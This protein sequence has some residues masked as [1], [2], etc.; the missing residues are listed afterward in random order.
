MAL[1]LGA[2]LPRLVLVLLAFALGTATLTFAA[3]KQMASQ[4]APPAATTPAQPVT[5]VVPDVEK[6]AYVFAKGILQD[7]GFAWRLGPGARGFAPYTVISQ[8][9]APGTKVVDTGA[10]LVTLRL[11]AT[12]GYK[13]SRHTPDSASP[14]AGTAIR[15]AGLAT[16][17]APTAPKVKPKVAPKPAAKPMPKARVTKTKPRTSKR[18]AAIATRKPDFV[19][20]GARKEPANEIPLTVRA[21][22]LDG[23][24]KAHTRVDDAV[25]RY[26]LFQNSWIVTGA[27]LGWWHGAQ[28]LQT[29]IAVDERAQRQWGIGNRS[30]AEARAALGFVRSQRR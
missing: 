19:V 29:L 10:P 1:R 23:W 7:A 9:P 2:V 13:E 18:A 26:W 14:Y 4:T 27:R 28:A 8:S 30:A 6:Q 24:V 16:N 21:R 25:A 20:P 3:A 5:L 15:P 17:V 12:A 22:R 11:A